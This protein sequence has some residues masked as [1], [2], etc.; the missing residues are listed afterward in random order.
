M[1]EEGQEAQTDRGIVGEN[2]HLR[3][4]SMEPC[5]GIS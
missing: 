2:A 3:S 5:A 4:G 1:D